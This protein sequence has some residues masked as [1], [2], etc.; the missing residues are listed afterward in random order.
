MIIFEKAELFILI[1]LWVH[2]FVI[3]YSKKV[4]YIQLVKMVVEKYKIV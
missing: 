3:T 2:I 1:F 4:I